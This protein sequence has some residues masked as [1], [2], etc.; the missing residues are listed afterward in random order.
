MSHTRFPH[1]PVEH[2]RDLAAARATAETTAAHHAASAFAIHGDPSLTTSQASRTGVQWVRPTDLAQRAGSRVLAR[3]VE[4]NTSLHDAVLEAGR[5]VHLRDA[6]R[7][8]ESAL[9]LEEPSATSN[10]V[11]GRRA[12]GR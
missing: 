9:S 1:D 2:E 12:V 7:R 6:L 11:A 5:S 8:R 10:R 3:G 4:L